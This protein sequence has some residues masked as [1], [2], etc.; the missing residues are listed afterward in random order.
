MSAVKLRTQ[1]FV[2]FGAG[3]MCRAVLV[4]NTVGEQE[5]RLWPGS[6][7]HISMGAADDAVAQISS[8]HRFIAAAVGIGDETGDLKGMGRDQG[9]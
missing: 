5:G 8:H 7:Q 6:Y 3:W 4:G 9:A 2:V 1:V